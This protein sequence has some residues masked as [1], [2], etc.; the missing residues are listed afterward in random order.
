MVI[1]CRQCGSNNNSG[2]RLCLI[3][4]AGL[5]DS[6]ESLAAG[7]MTPEPRKLTS[8]SGSS[9]VRPTAEANNSAVYSFQTDIHASH[10]GRHLVLILFTLTVAGACWHWQDLRM[11]AS[12]FSQTP[13][14]S[15]SKEPS[16]TPASASI[17]ALDVQTP[18]R[19]Q[20][21]PSELAS[22]P[23]Q[24]A[25]EETPSQEPSQ[26]RSPRSSRGR[27]QPLSASALDNTSETEGEKYLYGDG[28]PVNCG[29]A[30]QDLLAAAEHSSTKAQSALGTMYATGH[31]AIRD[32]PLAY[33]WFA[34]AQRRELRNRIIEEDMRVLWNQMSP[35]ERRL[36]KR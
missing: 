20:P 25:T 13:D 33:H 26:E 22:Q 18:Q 21:G 8:V 30:R 4:G 12:R 34:R 36:A 5:L 1:R 32:L 24:S 19:T 3:C 10:L 2:N 35:E 23:N 11:F 29:R 28:V 14:M 9:M 6:T 16:S 31:C 17:P 27:I 7:Q 15:Q